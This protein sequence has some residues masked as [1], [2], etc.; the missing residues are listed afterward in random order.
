MESVPTLC[1]P[2]LVRLLFDGSPTVFTVHG[3]ANT[4]SAVSVLNNLLNR[5]SNTRLL[6]GELRADS[7]VFHICFLTVMGGEPATS[8]L[9]IYLV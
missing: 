3:E 5:T 2:H 1:Y 9:L 6:S 8:V 7:D 4:A